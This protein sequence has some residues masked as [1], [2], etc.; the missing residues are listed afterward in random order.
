MVEGAGGGAV[1]VVVGARV[2]LVV[3]GVVCAL[4]GNSSASAAAAAWTRS[5][6]RSLMATA[7][8]PPTW[9]AALHR[10]RTRIA[11]RERVIRGM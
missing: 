4:V 10:P 5:G 11:V 6:A 1:V 3:G 9:R 8:R 7:V 2:V